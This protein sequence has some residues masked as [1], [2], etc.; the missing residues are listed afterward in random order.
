MG[1]LL[2]RGTNIAKIKNSLPPT[3]TVCTRK[4]LLFNS[5]R[6]ETVVKSIVLT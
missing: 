1:K 2:H 4:F 5:A 6:T 3:R